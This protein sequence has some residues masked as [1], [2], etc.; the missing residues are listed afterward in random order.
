M[1]EQLQDMNYWPQQLNFAVWC[2]TSGCG[3]SPFESLNYPKVVNGFIKFH[4]Y[5]TIRRIL[6]ELSLPLPDEQPFV[7]NNN[8][9]SKVAYQRLCKEFGISNTEDFRFKIGTNN[10]L[11]DIFYKYDES[12]PKESQYPG[13]DNKFSD[14]LTEREKTV[15]KGLQNFFK[16]RR[17]L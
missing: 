2:A 9:Y 16:K 3:I 7:I 12:S 10:G 11:G 6:Y 17:R 13:G 4:I 1:V 15:A 14:D 8:P 5:F